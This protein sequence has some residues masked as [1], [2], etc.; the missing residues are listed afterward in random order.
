MLKSSRNE[1]EN[2]SKIRLV[3]ET[4][5]LEPSKELKK[6]KIVSSWD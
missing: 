2:L 5:K 6:K 1:S 3:G 4:D